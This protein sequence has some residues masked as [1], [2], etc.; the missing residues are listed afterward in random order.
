MA[1]APTLA[2]VLAEI[3][4][5]KRTVKAQQRRLRTCEASLRAC[6]TAADQTREEM[7][8]IQE[9]STSI[10]EDIERFREQI[11]DNLAGHRKQRRPGS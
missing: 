8:A 11:A 5:L 2:D 9:I 7:A 1:K 10:R 3:E 4:R 6:V